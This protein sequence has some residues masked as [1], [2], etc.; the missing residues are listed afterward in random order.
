MC[1]NSENNSE[2]RFKT[3]Q[4]GGRSSVFTGSKDRAC[5]RESR[6]KPGVHTNDFTPIYGRRA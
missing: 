4:G 5:D 2:N 1:H 3:E 6:L